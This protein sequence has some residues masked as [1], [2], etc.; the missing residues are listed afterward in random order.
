MAI[1]TRSR[2]GTKWTEADYRAAGY[3]TLKVRLPRG[4]KGRIEKLAA[5]DGVSVAKW[6]ETWVLAAERELAAVA[7]GEPESKGI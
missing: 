1:V 5:G 2:S 6:L 3:F 7:P 4:L